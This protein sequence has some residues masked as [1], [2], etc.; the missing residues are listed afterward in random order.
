M[1]L[2]FRPIAAILPALLIVLA[3]LMV[4][5]FWMDDQLNQQRTELQRVE[6]QLAQCQAAVYAVAEPERD[7]A[8]PHLAFWENAGPCLDIQEDK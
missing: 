5:V 6:L 4:N 1:K 8:A 3:I 2:Q 7:P